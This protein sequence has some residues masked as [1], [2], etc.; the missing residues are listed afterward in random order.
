[1]FGARGAMFGARGAVFGARGAVFGVAGRLGCHLGRAVRGPS[2]CPV[3]TAESLG[4]LQE[5]NELR[6]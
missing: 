2:S 5:G 6:K 1:M 4:S 3:P